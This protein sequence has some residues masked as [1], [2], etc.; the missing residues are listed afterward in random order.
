[1]LAVDTFSVCSGWGVHGDVCNQGCAPGWVAL[2]GTPNKTCVGVTWSGAPLVCIPAPGGTSGG[3]PLGAEVLPA[4]YGSCSVTLLSEPFSNPS[5][6]LLAWNYSGTYP[7]FVGSD[8]TLVFG[9]MASSTGT[10]S[11][12]VLLGEMVV[13][14]APFQT[15]PPFVVLHSGEEYWLGSAV[16]AAGGGVTASSPLSSPFPVTLTVTLTPLRGS[17]GLVW[18]FLDVANH[19]RVRLSSYAPNASGTGVSVGC[20]VVVESVINGTTLALNST[21]ACTLGLGQSVTLSVVFWPGA[22]GGRGD[23]STTTAT[24]ILLNGTTVLTATA[25]APL[26]PSPPTTTTT[27]P[28]L[29]SVG[30]L[31]HGPSA[32]AGYWGFSASL[33]C[34][35]AASLQGA[36]SPPLSPT[37]SLVITCPAAPQ[38]LGGVGAAPGPWAAVPSALAVVGGAGEG[39]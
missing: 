25:A 14:P 35:P 23:T 13:S 18:G 8:K 3:C 29:G 38:Q 27:L 32:K 17:A 22:G 5:N 12:Q 21:Q 11:S 2:R 34:P 36:L 39:C 31:L 33:P 26:P 7:Y 1:M 24:R 37:Q 9:A 19:A 16:A 28:L 30:L 4:F 6:A 10:S 15:P 20:S